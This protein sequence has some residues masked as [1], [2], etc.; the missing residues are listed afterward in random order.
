[1]TSSVSGCFRSCSVIVAWRS[2]SCSP[3]HLR[4]RDRHAEPADPPPEQH[5]HVDLG[6]ADEADGRERDADLRLVPA[7]GAAARAVPH[8]VGRVVLARGRRREDV[9]LHAQRVHEQVVGRLAV[10][11]GVEREADPV[12]LEQVVAARERAAHPLRLRVVATESEIQG[13]VVEGNPHLGP[14]R[15]VIAVQRVVR[16]PVRLGHGGAPARRRRRD[17]RRSWAGRGA[18]GRQRGPVLGRS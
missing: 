13:A 4:P 9:A 15:D 2:R 6:A 18:D 3:R 16:Q 5:V 8:E 11:D 12:V 17:A 7:V 10:A 1:M 14:L